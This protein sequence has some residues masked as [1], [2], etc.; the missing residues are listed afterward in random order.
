MKQKGWVPLEADDLDCAVEESGF[1]LSE[2]GHLVRGPRGE[3]MIFKMDRDDYRQLEAAKASQNMRG[4]GS[5]KRIK[6][7]MAEAAAG[8]LGSE[9]ADYIHGLDGAVVDRITGGEAG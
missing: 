5:Q 8:A 9:A 7:D 2:T 4:I 1:R 3:E 6:S